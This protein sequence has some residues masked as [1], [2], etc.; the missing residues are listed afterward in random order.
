MRKYFLILLVIY[1]GSQMGGSHVG[2]AQADAGNAPAPRLVLMISI[3]QMRYDYLERFEPLYKSGLRQ[4]LDGAGIFTNA[5]YRHASSETGPGHSVLLTGT[6]PSHSGIVANDWWDPYLNRT[7]NV[8][9]DPVQ[10]TVG[11]N[12]RASSPANLLTFTVGDVLKAKSP[13][14]RVVG[15]GMKDRSAILMG[16]RRADAAY[17]FENDGGNFVSSTYYMDAAP[18]WL[19]EWNKKRNADRFAA[20]GWTRLL[21]DVTLYEKY[22]GRDAVEGERDRKDIVFPHPFVAM[23]PKSE[24]YVELRRSPFADEVVLDFALEA[25]KQH[26]L[27]KDADTDIFAVGFAAADGIGHQWG[28][29]SQEQMDQLLRLD[30]VLGRLLAHVDSTV[31]LSNT[32]V[33]LSAD[34]GVRQLVEVSQEKGIPARRVPPKVLQNAVSAAFGQRYPG[35]KDLISFFAIDFYLNEESVRR[36]KLDWKDVEKTAIDAIYSTG[37]VEKVYTHDDLRSLAPSSDPNLRLFQN[38]FYPPRSPHLNVMLKPEIYMNASVGGTSHGS[39]YE[40]DR[41]VPIVFMGR[42]IK[43][44]R[45]ANESGPEDIAPTI[46]NLLGLAFPHEHDSRVLLEMLSRPQT[47]TQSPQK[48]TENTA[49]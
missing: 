39:V 12:G 26:A 34:H 9:D 43:P 45:Y 41:H 16:G 49:Q 28:P 33:V 47:G 42:M 30:G 23:P 1:I 18:A 31:G 7:M 17:W 14:S 36:N 6:H 3:D 27:G 2:Y 22:A 35:V 48:R 10:R 46:A 20:R 29:D 32:L 25:M 44:G 4:L 38:A 24:Y 5:K 15:I 13:R 11:G 8:I 19:N 40:Y 37:L 21:D